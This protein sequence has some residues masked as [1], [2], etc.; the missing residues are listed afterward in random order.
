MGWASASEIFDPVAV[1]MKELRIPDMQRTEVLEVLIREMRILDWDTEDESLARF[2]DDPA[3][4]E[5]FRRNEVFARCGYVRE[6]DRECD[7][8]QGHPPDFHMDWT[9]EK[10][11][12]R[13]AQEEA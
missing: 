12:V 7:R 4:V 1:R 10:W 6:D 13:A 2:R 3:V 5:A 9:M 8:E 11:P